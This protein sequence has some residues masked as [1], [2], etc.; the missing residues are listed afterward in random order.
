MNPQERVLRKQLVELLLGRG[1]HVDLETAV[2]GMPAAARGRRPPG[3]E[4]T[5]WQVL[6]H[7][8][9]AQWDILEFSRSA[10]HISPPW[11]AGYWPTAEAP[12]G[13]RAW[14]GCVAAIKRDRKEMIRLVEDPA[15]DLY[16]PIPHGDGQTILREAMLIADHNS[17]H[18]GELVTLRRLLGVWGDR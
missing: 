7:I 13:P 8:R 10:K 5:P 12:P 4:H 3:A 17:Y 11:P 15:T 2:R 16:S 9:I 14:S 1:A 6:E 18:L